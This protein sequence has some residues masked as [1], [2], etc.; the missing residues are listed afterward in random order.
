MQ[1]M[2]RGRSAPVECQSPGIGG[3]DMESPCMYDGVEIAGRIGLEGGMS[4]KVVVVTDSCVGLPDEMYA[5]YSIL[6]VPYYVHL[7]EETRRDLVD[8]DRD[9][10]LAHLLTAEEL[11]KTANPGP[12]DYLEA[13]RE[14]A[15]RTDEII[16]LHMTSKG[17]GAYQAA[18]VAKG[19]L[20]QERPELRIEV[21]DT[22]N[23]SMC[24]G[25]MTLEAARAAAAGW[26]MD[27]IT[28]LVR[29]MIPVAK[30]IQTADTLKYLYMGGRI[31]RAKH[32]VASL[33][34][35]KPL[36]SMDDGVI[37]ALG[38][39]R[40]RVA[41]YRRIVELMLDDVGPGRRVKVAIVHFGDLEDAVKLRDM[42]TS[43]VP[44]DEILMSQLS[45]ALAVHTGPGT[46]GVCYFPV[47][48]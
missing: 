16:S 40:S 31:G 14:A 33:L 23:V 3:I 28:S 18:L 48:E 25:W 19:M 35:I 22:L 9:E 41:A 38:V 6:M 24:H 20:A 37:V 10:F 43:R 2:G 7:G 1:A 5:E 27:E 32:L 39:A 42:V 12:G 30:M 17:S 21:V 13:F 46:V 26:P 29:R 36:I 45:P 11:P 4:R 44:C 8:I 47:L 15:Q 34:R